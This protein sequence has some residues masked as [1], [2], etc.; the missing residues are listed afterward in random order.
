MS[1]KEEINPYWEGNGLISP[2]PNPTHIYRTCDNGCMYVSE[3][4]IMLNR[5]GELAP[6]DPKKYDS[7]IRT[8]LTDGGLLCR[9][10]GDKGQEG[11]DDYH[12]VLAAC[13]ELR[14]FTLGQTLL[15]Y[16]WKNFWVLNNEKPGSIKKLDGS[17]NWASF[18]F[19]FPTIIAMAYAASGKAPIWSWPFYWYS[20][21]VIRYSAHRNYD[22]NDADSRRLCWLLIQ[23]VKGKSW[24]CRKASQV[25]YRKLYQEFPGGMKSIARIYYR[26]NEG[27]LVHPFIK[28]WID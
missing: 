16:G 28:Y 20:A 8:C 25:W 27:D 14:C 2:S 26:P 13:V 23:A 3:Y 6:D 24:L 12:G 5:N 11:P 1:L 4:Y 7:L 22:L 9:A 19:R 15:S 17:I 10:P 21:L 18:F